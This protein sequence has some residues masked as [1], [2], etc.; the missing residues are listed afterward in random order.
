V[1]SAVILTAPAGAGNFGGWSYNCIPLAA[2]TAAGPNSCEVF[3][4][5]NDTVGAVFN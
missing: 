5:T 2:I 4:T 1:G 3:L